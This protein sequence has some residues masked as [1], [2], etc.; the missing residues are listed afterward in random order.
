[1]FNIEI[2]KNIPMPTGSLTDVMKKMEV[3][4]SFVFPI[5]FRNGISTRSSNIGIKT[6]TKKISENECRV[7]RIE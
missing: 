1:M 7:W 3:G 6:K 2:E 5:N 4:D